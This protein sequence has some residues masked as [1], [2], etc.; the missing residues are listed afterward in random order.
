MANPQER[1]QWE[2]L[3]DQATTQALETMYFSTVV[4]PTETGPAPEESIAAVVSFDGDAAGAFW[5]T[6]SRDAAGELASNFLGEDAEAVE[7]ERIE[8]VIAE[9]T[10]ILCGSALSG[11]YPEGRFVLAAPVLMGPATGLA[12]RSV[13]RRSYELDTGSLS[14]ALALWNQ[15]SLRPAAAAV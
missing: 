4:G 10:N 7:P 9:M 15:P 12:G 5:V 13:V 11:F 3:L 14:V 1:G 6:V 2:S 8:S